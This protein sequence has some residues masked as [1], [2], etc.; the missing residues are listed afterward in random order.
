M[1][2]NTRSTFTFFSGDVGGEKGSY[3]DFIKTADITVDG[4]NLNLYT[5]D[6]LFD[7]FGKELSVKNSD[8]KITQSQYVTGFYASM[9]AL[10]K[11]TKDELF[12][13]DNDE[14]IRVL[15]TLLIYQLCQIPA[16]LENIQFGLYC[17]NP[18]EKKLVEKYLKDLGKNGVIF[19][20]QQ[21]KT[22]ELAASTGENPYDLINRYISNKDLHPEDVVSAFLEEAGVKQDLK[23]Q[24]AK[25]YNLPFGEDKR[26]RDAIRSG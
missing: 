5:V 18:S 25:G 11:V 24:K 21:S 7:F 26:F 16:S 8:L 3:A 22:Y 6:R 20:R 13:L 17:F 14:R 10:R 4:G 19:Y 12:R 23:F 9:D 1:D 15:K 2:P